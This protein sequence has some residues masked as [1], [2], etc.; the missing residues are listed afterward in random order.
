MRWG[1]IVAYLRQLAIA[2]AVW[3]V[4]ALVY[5]FDEVRAAQFMDN[6]HMAMWDA[7]RPALQTYS[8][9][10]LLTPAVIL[11]AIRMEP[12]RKNWRAFALRHVG[13]FAV[14]GLIQAV[15]RVLLF[16]VHNPRT[17]VVLPRSLGLIFGV[18]ML[19]LND[20]IFIYL[21]LAA[22]ATAWAA[23]RQTRERELA[24]SHLRERLA[25]AELQILKMQLHPHFLFNTLQAISTLV[26]KDPQAAKRMIA[27]LGDLLH[28][29]I[30]RTGEQEIPLSS[31]LDLLDQ[32][33]QIEL[34]RFGD[35]LHVDFAVDD[36]SLNA[37]VPSLLLQPLVEN[38]IRHGARAAVGR[39]AVRV[40]S[41][42]R[43]NR[44]LLTVED[45]GPGITPTA[46]RNRSGLGLEN[47]RARLEGLYGSNQILEMANLETGGLRLTVEIP[48]R[49]AERP[50]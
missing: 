11:F 37:M 14:F 10:A 12:Q 17:W 41:G 46:E 22:S 26:G 9:Y 38:A 6:R 49:F 24:Q 5:A 33:V 7:L 27:L 40:S 23:F 50:A 2:C 1:P 36:R 25:G 15:L 19:F 30:D 32:Y 29:A 44:L 43:D 39:G 34:V 16:P 21:P 3:A 8:A 31:E 45:N 48:L 42:M 35:K 28:S 13:G 20:D 4:L 47:T 18:F